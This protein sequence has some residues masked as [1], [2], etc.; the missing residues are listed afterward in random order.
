MKQDVINDN[1]HSSA[2]AS[3][4]QTTRRAPI[5][6]RSLSTGPSWPSRRASLTLM[7]PKARI[8]HF[9][10][11]CPSCVLARRT[12][13]SAAYGNE[14]ELGVAIKKSGVPRDRLFVT[15]KVSG[16]RADVD[17]EAAFSASLAKLG[18][19]HVNLYLIHAPF[20]AKGDRGVLQRKWADME[21]I[22]A[23]GRAR[24]IGVSNFSIA[25]LEAVL[26]T[27][28]EKPVCNQI[29]FHPYLQHVVPGTDYDLLAFH[30]KHDIATVAYG[31]LSALTK[32]RPGPLDA[33]YA[34][35]ARKY[36]VTEGEVALRWC[37]DQGIVTLTTSK[38]K[39]RIESLL[40]NVPSFK[41]TPQEVDEIAQKGREKHLRVF[42]GNR[43]A[44]DDKR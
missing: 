22:K 3:A 41:L 2:T 21:R 33:T 29:E 6:P 34:E 8:N 27:A 26:E 12:N 13:S 42:W 31:P 23:S 15:T 43:Y 37:I 24:S 7:A 17:T 4:L 20:F 19:D 25:D 1:I 11:Q 32:G 10:D 35:L 18:L 44:P 30:R 28:K 9:H 5:S 40:R 14:E 16:T 38:S 39:E 36:G